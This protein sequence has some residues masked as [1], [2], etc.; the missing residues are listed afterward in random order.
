VTQS[1][2]GGI[3]TKEKEIT[4]EGN[5]KQTTEETSTHKRENNVL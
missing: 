1:T 3:K 2:L 4:K 5:K